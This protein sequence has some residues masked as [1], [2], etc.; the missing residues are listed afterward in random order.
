[1]RFGFYRYY[2]LGG[3]AFRFSELHT[4]GVRLHSER[5]RDG[6]FQSCRR[7]QCGLLHVRPWGKSRPDE[8]LL[9]SLRAYLNRA[10]QIATNIGA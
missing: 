4:T 3:I 5:S 9:P 8:R 6:R 10:T 7:S 1:V 2:W